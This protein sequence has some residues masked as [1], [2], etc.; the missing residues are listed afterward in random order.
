MKKAILFLVVISFFV[1]AT[2]AA[3]E[4]EGLIP[5]VFNRIFKKA[6]TTTPNEPKPAEVAVQPQ[7]PKEMPKEVGKE[8][9]KEPATKMKTR[10]AMTSAELAE[11]IK[12]ML[13]H[14]DEIL[15]FIPDLKKEKDSAGNIFY[16]YQGLKIENMDKERL[17][18][19]FSRIQNEAV[20]VR[21]ERLNKQLESIRQAQQASIAA[22]QASRVPTVVTPPRPPQPP[23]TPPK[24]PP[25]PPAPPRR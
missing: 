7:A 12:G 22:Q 8:S 11:H 6:K 3:E 4:T 14:E 2:S 23:P 20:R 17:D 18:K 13:E 1:A 21:T 25:P 9:A 19:L 15:N 24:P 16:T 5:R 10:T